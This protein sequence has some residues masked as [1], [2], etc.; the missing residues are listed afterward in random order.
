MDPKTLLTAPELASVLRVSVATIYGR[1]KQRLLP[2]YKIGDRLVFD[3]GEVLE[4]LRRPAENAEDFEFPK[5]TAVSS[6]RR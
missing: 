1:A 4:S 6:G 2:H 3:V 5:M